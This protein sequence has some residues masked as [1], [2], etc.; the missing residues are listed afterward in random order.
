[1]AIR[2]GDLVLLDISAANHDPVVFA[3][4]QRVDIA[5]KDGAHLTFGHGGRYCIGAPLARIE[6]KAVFAQLIPRFPSLHVAVDPARLP[7][8]RDVLAGGLVELP[9]SW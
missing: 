4:P 9:V 8:R 5:R 7:T 6:L 2:A 3:D 1:V